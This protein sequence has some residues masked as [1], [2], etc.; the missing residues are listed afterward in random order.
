MSAERPPTTDTDRILLGILALLAADRDERAEG[1]T[2]RR[3]EVILDTAGFSPREISQL[4]GR[5]VEAV[6]STVRRT[7]KA[8]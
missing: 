5:E 3:T 8:A 7:K 2:L 1:T 4:L 6:R